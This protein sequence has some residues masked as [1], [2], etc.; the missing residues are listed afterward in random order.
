MPPGSGVVYRGFGRSEGL[1]E[2][3]RLRTITRLRGMTLLIGLDVDLA[4]AVQADGLHLP[5]RSVSAAYPLSGRRPDW[6]LTGAVHSVEAA[7]AARDLDAVLLSPIYP[8]GGASAVKPAL[9]LDAMRAAS[10]GRTPVMALG[11]VTTSNV[12][13]LTDTGCA[14]V[15]AIGGIADA[16][17]P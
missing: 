8:A 4:D 5:E 14:G 16:F 15:A 12:G 9:G 1:E 13:A 7:L 17:G 10:R 2:A 6:I 11:G 3:K